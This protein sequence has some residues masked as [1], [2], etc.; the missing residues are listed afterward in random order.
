MITISNDF[1]GIELKHYYFEEFIICGIPIPAYTNQTG[2]IIKFK[3]AESYLKYINV[4]KLILL[5]LELADPDN[6]KY[7]IQRSKLFIINLL[8]IMK[9][10]F[11][12]K[13][14]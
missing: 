13:Y 9:K 4:L 6:C 1:L 12:E 5:D 3:N 11:S 10:G 14:N 2:L 8:H 7:E